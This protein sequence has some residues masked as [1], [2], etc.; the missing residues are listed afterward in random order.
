VVT[1][2]GGDSRTAVSYGEQL[3]VTYGMKNEEAD[4]RRKHNGG[5]LCVTKYLAAL[6]SSSCVFAV[7]HG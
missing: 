4:E 5:G 3:R 6:S 2:C 1:E 7:L